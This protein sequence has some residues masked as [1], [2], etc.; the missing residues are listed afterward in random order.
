MMKVSVFCI[1]ALSYVLS[2]H[3]ALPTRDAESQCL[4]R[5]NRH[6]SISRQTVILPL[7]CSSD[8]NPVSIFDFAMSFDSKCLFVVTQVDPIGAAH[9]N[10][11]I[12]EAVS[13]PRA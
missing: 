3:T 7:A 10:H 1:R 6:K 2:Y 8:R 4:M 11:I 9:D 13:R 12:R 5:G